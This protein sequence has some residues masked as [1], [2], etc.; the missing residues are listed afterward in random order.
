M[1][2]FS[3]YLTPDLQFVI[4]KYIPHV[5]LAAL[6]I[7]YTAWSHHCFQAEVMKLRQEVNDNHGVHR[8]ASR[9][10]DGIHAR[11]DYVW[12]MLTHK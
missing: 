9:R 4:K 10:I 5:L 7:A 1:K 12:H 2:K 8:D 3:V 6:T 11:L